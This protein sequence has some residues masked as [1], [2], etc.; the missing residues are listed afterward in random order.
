M[1]EGWVATEMYWEVR[2]W[3]YGN[4]APRPPVPVWVLGSVTAKR[5]C[6]F[7]RGVYFDRILI[8]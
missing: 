2:F 3:P 7:A 6:G 1:I 5:F 8:A 4:L